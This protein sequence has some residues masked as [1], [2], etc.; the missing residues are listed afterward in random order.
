M[1][2][3]SGTCAENFET[4]ASQTTEELGR[5]RTA[6]VT[7]IMNDV[8]FDIVLVA[9]Q[10]LVVEQIVEAEKNVQESA[11]ASTPLSMALMKPL[12]GSVVL[13]TTRR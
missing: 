3:C 12:R 5:E 8:E 13:W 1:C 4:S 9:N 7:T 10:I 2:T 11:R 6:R